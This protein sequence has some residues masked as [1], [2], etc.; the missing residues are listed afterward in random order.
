MSPKEK[1]RILYFLQR[2]DLFVSIENSRIHC[3]RGARI[4]SFW[5]FVHDS[6]PQKSTRFGNYLVPVPPSLI[7]LL[8]SA[9]VEQ[10]AGTCPPLSGKWTVTKDWSSWFNVRPKQSH[11][12]NSP[13]HK[14][15]YGCILVR[16][17]SR[18]QSLFHCQGKD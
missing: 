4:L 3:S 8:A 12:S 6:L 7:L 11:N 13:C 2:E 18:L 5:L 15:C 1:Y 9:L 17:F 14:P 16:V 10:G